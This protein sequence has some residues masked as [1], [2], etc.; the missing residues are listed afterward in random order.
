[1]EAGRIFT[2]GLNLRAFTHGQ[3]I[4]RRELLR[5]QP[6][7]IMILPNLWPDQVNGRVDYLWRKETRSAHYHSFL[8]LTMIVNDLQVAWKFG[9]VFL[10]STVYDEFL[11]LSLCLAKP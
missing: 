9:P 10:H 11:K 3:L 5:T 2:S 7:A 8:H 4:S 6:K 1:M